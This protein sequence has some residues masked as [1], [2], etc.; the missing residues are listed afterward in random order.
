MQT[1]SAL[2]ALCAGNSPVTGVFPSQRPVT[3]SFDVFLD[4]RLNKRSSKQLWGWRFK[5]PSRSLLRHVINISLHTYFHS[6]AWH[7]GLLSHTFWQSWTDLIINL[8]V[9]PEACFLAVFLNSHFSSVGGLSLLTVKTKMRPKC[10]CNS[11]VNPFNSQFKE[12]T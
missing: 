4:L 2:L 7:L 11:N 1:F 8:D 10:T 5:T 9:Q 6:N 12:L 3:R